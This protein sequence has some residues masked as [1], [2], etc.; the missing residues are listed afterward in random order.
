M[1]LDLRSR[2][3]QTFGVRRPGAALARDVATLVW[4][5]YHPALDAQSDAKLADVMK[6]VYALLLSLVGL[7]VVI[8]NR[9]AAEET[10]RILPEWVWWRP[11]VLVGRIMAIVSGTFFVFFGLL[12]MMGYMQ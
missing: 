4:K 2:N 3:T 8:L 1:I 12:T 11:T 5:C 10:L 9:L 6:N 7:L